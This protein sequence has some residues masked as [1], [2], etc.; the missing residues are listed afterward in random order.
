[1]LRRITC[2]IKSLHTG[3]RN[4]HTDRHTHTET[5]THT[6]T[7][8]YIYIYIYI[9]I[10]YIYTEERER[11]R[12]SE[13]YLNTK[14]KRIPGNFVPK[15]CGFKLEQI[16]TNSFESYLNSEKIKIKNPWA[17][18]LINL[19]PFARKV[20]FVHLFNLFKFSFLYQLS[21]HK[22]QW[23]RGSLFQACN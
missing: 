15:V 7:H 6:H 4:T 23:N 5:D 12:E 16:T 18:N 17:T 11:E 21:R 2:E 13:A 3:C 20:S 19:P 22:F 1:M 10:I 14:V 8:V 9:Y